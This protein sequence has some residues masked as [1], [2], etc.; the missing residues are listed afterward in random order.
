MENATDESGASEADSDRESDD[1]ADEAGGSDST[2]S[3]HSTSV[4][5]QEADCV[6]DEEEEGG[7]RGQM[8]CPATPLRCFFVVWLSTAIF[9][10]F[11]WSDFFFVPVHLFRFD[12]IISSFVSNFC[13]AFILDHVHLYYTYVSPQSNVD[14]F[15]K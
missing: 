6:G 1:G 5:E 7:K 14:L 15:M 9:T 4:S 10:S 3:S 13:S 12:S 2:E 11:C 8:A